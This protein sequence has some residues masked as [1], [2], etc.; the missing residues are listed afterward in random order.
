MNDLNEIDL[1]AFVNNN[2]N[3]IMNKIVN[4]LQQITDRNA[5]ITKIAN[6]KR[7]QLKKPW[8]TNSVLISIKKNKKLCKTH[9]FN[10]DPEKIKQFKTYNNK[11]NKIKE[12]AKK[13]FFISI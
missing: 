9:F 4:T 12:A 6:S 11:L 13:V 2:V 7:R 8:I 1:K 10:N 3:E 5:P